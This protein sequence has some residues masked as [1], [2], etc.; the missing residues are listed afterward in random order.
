MTDAQLVELQLHPNEWYVR[1][2]RRLL[3]ERAAAGH[4]DTDAVHARL[5][6]DRAAS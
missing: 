2:A 6:V 3:Q 5:V 4:L 1:M